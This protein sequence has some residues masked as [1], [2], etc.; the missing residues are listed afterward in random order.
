MFKCFK[1]K[2]ILSLVVLIGLLNPLNIAFAKNCKAFSYVYEAVIRGTPAHAG[3]SQERTWSYNR[4]NNAASDDIHR[5]RLNGVLKDTFRIW[6]KRRPELVGKWYSDI[7]SAAG[8]Q[9]PNHESW[10]TNRMKRGEFY[11]H[12]VKRGVMPTLEKY[13]Y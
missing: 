6:S 13:W 9:N 8:N 2:V 7:E 1:N 11:D 10:A 3:V 4:C 12:I 5:G